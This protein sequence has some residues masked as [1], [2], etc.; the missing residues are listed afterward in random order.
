MY[1]SSTSGKYVLHWITHPDP[2]LFFSGFQNADK[3]KFFFINFLLA[4]YCRYSISKSVFKDNKILG[5]HKSKSQGFSF[6]FLQCCGSGIFIP[7]P[8][9]GSRIQIFTHPWSKNSNKREGWK[10]I[11]VIPFYVDTNFTKLKIILVLKCRRKIFWPIFKELENFLPKQLS[12]CSQNY[13][14]GIRDPR[15]GIRK[16]PILDPGSRGQKGT[17]SRIPDSDPQ[18]CFF[19]CWW[20]YPD[21]GGPNTDFTDPEGYIIYIID[22]TFP[23]GYDPHMSHSPHL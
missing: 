3:N 19:A 23:T 9:S 4:T 17:G 7:D 21:P 12:I 22:R 15:S 16:K 1:R 11:V 18:H 10:K 8:G 5:S 13:G 20:N 14:F 2:A 6:T